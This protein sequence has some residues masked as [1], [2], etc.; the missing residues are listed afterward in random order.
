MSVQIHRH[1]LYLPGYNPENDKDPVTK[2]GGIANYN[3]Y[4]GIILKCFGIATAINIKGQFYY[5]NKKSWANWNHRHPEYAISETFK[6]TQ[7][8]SDRS[9]LDA[10]IE[11]AEK[12]QPSHKNGQPPSRE[13]NVST[14]VPTAKASSG[15]AFIE[16]NIDLIETKEAMLKM[17]N[18]LDQFTLDLTNPDI[19]GSSNEKDLFLNDINQLKL[20]IQNSLETPLDFNNIKILGETLNQSHA[21]VTTSLL[22]FGKTPFFNK[23]E[24]PEKNQFITKQISELLALFIPLSNV[25]ALSYVSFLLEE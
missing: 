4:L 23:I 21:K 18:F 8:S 19:Y 13:K 9:T 7:Y 14:E 3:K 11:E 16:K 1:R 6:R 12:I 20:T 5:V 10:L 17:F 25:M 2:R 22:S 24:P 15:Q